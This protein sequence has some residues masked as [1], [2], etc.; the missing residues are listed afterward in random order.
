M[1]SSR[2]HNTL[3]SSKPR[4]KLPL[5][6]AL[7]GLL[8]ATA[9]T[10]PFFATNDNMSAALAAEQQT[11]AFNPTQGFADLVEQVQP[12]VVSIQV[13]SGGIEL[14]SNQGQS[15]RE[16]PD[17]SE[18][19][20]S[21]AGVEKGQRGREGEQDGGQR[22]G[23]QGSEEH[24]RDERQ[25]G[26]QRRG[27]G[28]EQGPG[29]GGRRP[30]PYAEAQGSGFI[31]SADGYVVTNH[32]VIEGASH[33][34]VTLNGGQ[35]FPA[36]IVGHDA[37][38]DLALLRIQADREFEFVSFSS[39][40][41]RVGDWV[42]AVG[43][44]FGLGGTVTT[45]IVSARG[46]DIGSGP[47][48]DYLQIDA[49]INRGNSGGPA[50]NLNGDVIGVNTAIYSPS[51]GNVGIGFAI[52][53][54]IALDVI[55]ELR[56]DGI[57]TR[58]WLGVHIQSVTEDIAESLELHNAAGA[59]VT[60][61]RSGSP[62]AIGDLRVGD[63]IVQ[64]NGE[65]VADPKDLARRIALIDPGQTAELALHREGELISI[66][67]EI[68]EMPGTQHQ[69]SASEP[70]DVERTAV[71][72]LGLTLEHADGDGVLISSVDEDSLAAL[73]GLREGDVILRI[74]NEAV[75]VPGDVERVFE[76]VQADGR[77]VLLMLVRS[78]EQQRFVTLK[79]DR[80]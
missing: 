29:N 35:S 52:P 28:F 20:E 44:P 19:D 17:S 32:H 27:N 36:E 63:L 38:T 42:V 61:V 67:I 40:E 13:S 24:D 5:A 10:V 76:E 15:R 6:L 73:T 70:E 4:T 68:G 47:Y 25:H 80:G 8:G 11:Y 7:A 60:E 59:L 79:L 23:S 39:E 31:I 78:G 66:A 65:D 74:G 49:P 48:D 18:R 9:L 43:N 2:Q 75:S 64:V 30:E 46:R 58:G 34:E 57:V 50:F 62:A 1:L 56:D 41:A 12:S 72:V 21:G 26:Q 69:A 16:S 14:S 22:R 53:A 54:A 51:G 33:V 3:R 37:K 55:E 71:E 77:S 45:G